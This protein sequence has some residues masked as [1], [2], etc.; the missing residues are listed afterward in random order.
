MDQGV[1]ISD[2]CVSEP[3]SCGKKVVV[4]GLGAAGPR[5]KP[6]LFMASISMA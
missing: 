4:G 3:V 5:L 1:L 6:A 2:G